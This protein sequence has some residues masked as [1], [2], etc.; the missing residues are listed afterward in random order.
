[1]FSLRNKKKLYMNY[2]QY[3]LLSG[4]L[5]RYITCQKV[6]TQQTCS[7]ASTKMNI[8]LDPRIKEGRHIF[9]T[10]IKLGISKIFLSERQHANKH[11]GTK[12]R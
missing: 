4:A 6:Y 8:E 12:N 7:V 3:L 1:M 2:P 9:T 11:F 10:H 5:K